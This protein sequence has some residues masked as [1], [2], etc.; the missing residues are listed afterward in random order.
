MIAVFV[1]KII[2]APIPCNA[3][4]AINIG[5]DVVTQLT[6]DISPNM[7]IPRINRRRLPVISANRPKGTDRDTVNSIYVVMIHES[8]A[9]GT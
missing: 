5:N 3:R 9:A 2:A 6:P 8:C 1:A 7:S 4:K